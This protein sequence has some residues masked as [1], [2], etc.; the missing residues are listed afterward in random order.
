[1]SITYNIKVF[2]I[3]QGVGFRPFIDRLAAQFNIRGTVANKG[4]YVE[5]YAQG[6]KMDVDN[7][8]D[9]I[10]ENQPPRSAILKVDKFVIDNPLKYKDFRIIE[11]EHEQGEIFV[12]PD[13]A[14]CDLC[15]EELFSKNNRRYLHPFI[16]CTACGP[17][18]TILKNMPYDRERTSMNKFP[19]CDSCS[20]E[21]YDSK[22]RRYDAQPVCCNECGPEVYILD[23]M[24]RGAAA[25]KRIRQVIQSGGI[26]AIKG[27]GGFHIACDAYNYETVQRLRNKKRRP[28]KPFAVMMKNLDVVKRE[29]D[30]NS[31]EIDKILDGHQKP[32]ILLDKN[33]NCRLAPNIAPDNQKI[34]VMLPYTPLHLLLFDYPDE[35]KNF[36]DALIMTSGNISGSPIAITDDEARQDLNNICDVILSHDREILLRADDSVMNFINGSPSMIRRSRGYAPLPILFNHNRKREILAIG[37]ELKNTFCLAKNQLFYPSPYIGDVG[38]FQAIDILKNSVERMSDLLEIKPQIIACDLHPRYHTTKIAEEFAEQL[39]TPIIKVQHHYAHVLSCMAENNFNEKVIGVA[40]DGTGYGIDGTIWGGEFLISDLNEFTRFDHITPFIQ[41]GGDKSS[42]EGWRIAAA[43]ILQFTND[44]NAAKNLALTLNIANEQQIDGQLFL[45][46]NNINCVTSTSAGRLFDAVSSIL[47]ACNSSTFEGEAAM[48]LEFNAQS[49]IKNASLP[50][51][52]STGE[53]F[54]FILQRRLSGENV[55]QLAFDFHSALANLIVNTCERA[56]LQSG[57]TTVALAGGVFQNSLL[58][59]LTNQR[60][61]ALN[62]KVLNHKLIPANDGGLCLGQALAACFTS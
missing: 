29:C 56:R 47:G 21:Y 34:G 60:L 17:R 59:T 10:E 40:F 15:K 18:L 57:I 28:Q 26:A 32:I 49:Q 27:I 33:K 23:G 4:S 39:N 8:C 30:Y 2:G 45:L 1:M 24:E 46:N 38:N 5:I 31:A 19:M 35:I 14:I 16:N 48:K 55:N 9:S 11:S 61:K 54:N 37:G 13:I 7:F 44:I 50:N 12:S 41:A 20:N 52:K 51:F 25:I 22:S 58:L 43:M 62:F 6:A 36:P 42:T 53:I 3:V